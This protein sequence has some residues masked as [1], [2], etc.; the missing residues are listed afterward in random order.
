MEQHI[1]LDLSPKRSLDGLRFNTADWLAL[2]GVLMCA[3]GYAFLHPSLFAA[4]N[5]LLPG[6]GMTISVWLMLTICMGYIGWRK[7]KWSLQSGFLLASSLLLSAA[8]GIFS[9][10]ILRYMNLPVL[11]ILCVLT[12]YSLKGDFPALDASVLTNAVAHALSSI[13]RH[14]PSPVFALRN[15]FKFG[16]SRR[17]KELLLGLGVCI[18]V[19]GLVLVLLCDADSM[20]G[21][22]VDGMF[23]GLR[24][25]SAGLLLW[26]LLRLL[27]LALMLFAFVYGLGRKFAPRGRNAG[28]PLLPELTVATVLAAMSIVY[29]VFVYVQGR[30]LFS[31]SEAALME[32]GYAVYARSGFF[33][34]VAVAFITMLIVLP[35][36]TRLP[37]SQ[38]LR[39][40]CA[41]VTL[42][43]MVIVV[44][45][46]WRMRLYI[47][48]F[49]LTFLRAVTL[50]GILAISAAMI[51]TLVKAARPRIRIFRPLFIFTICT[52]L[53]FN[54]ANVHARIAEYNLAAY[55]SGAL[56]TIDV[57]YLRLLGPE[58][59]PALD[60]LRQENQ[61]PV[62]QM[63]EV[64]RARGE[65][66]R[67]EPALYDWSLSWLKL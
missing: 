21:H 14:F 59:I 8:Y 48:Q 6:V 29:A 31:G 13:A 33:Q 46:F 65:I 15:Q 37:D 67:S 11:M 55:R 24:Q 30:Y 9:N 39:F 20:F 12:V 5:L 38:L 18:P 57:E 49:G 19:V 63:G 41:F 47:R 32:G 64:I 4:G 7:L 61:L 54:Y 62:E 58:A 23:S 17:V 25:P 36:L 3:A 45:A 28:K 1:D 27:I 34:L 40:L 52:W 35:I 53:A 10:N 43:T 60:L 16:D 2:L 42:L 22:L 44:S 66:I 50:W 51:A 26:N 56:E